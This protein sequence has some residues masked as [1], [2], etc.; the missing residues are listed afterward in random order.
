MD[1]RNLQK[2]VFDYVVER[3][4][5]IING[6]KRS[7]NLPS[8]QLFIALF[9]RRRLPW[10]ILLSKKCS[11]RFLTRLVYFFLLFIQETGFVSYDDWPDIVKNK[12]KLFVEMSQC[13]RCQIVRSPKV[14]CEGRFL[15]H[16]AF[17]DK[18]TNKQ[19]ETEAVLWRAACYCGMRWR[20]LA[21]VSEHAH[22]HDKNFNIAL[23]P[24]SEQQLQNYAQSW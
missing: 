7:N 3:W 17:T 8:L 6:L 23:P 5:R 1:V 2:K 22:I 10:S 13:W 12:N 16:C 21:T 19:Y 18:Q 9:Q 4:N 14:T 15:V 24:S 11:T 20:M